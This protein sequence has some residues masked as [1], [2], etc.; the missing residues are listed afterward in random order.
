MQNLTK[1]KTFSPPFFFNPLE[2]QIVTRIHM[3]KI[4]FFL[5]VLPESSGRTYF[6][7]TAGTRGRWA[8]R[9]R[10]AQTKVRLCL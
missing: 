9:C 4:P 8:T 6:P 10:E 3:N 7:P 2:M 5:E 1:K